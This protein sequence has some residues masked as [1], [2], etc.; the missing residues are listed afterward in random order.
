LVNILFSIILGLVQGV[1]EWLPISS[2]TQVLFASY[3]LFGL[4]IAA[5][6]AFG[7][8]LEIGSLGSA[9]TYFRKDIVALLHDR[10]LLTYLVVVTLFTAIVGAPL[11]YITDTY[12]QHASPFIGVPMIILG[13]ALVGIGF[14]IRYSRALPKIGGLEQMRI[15]HYI[16]VGIAQGIAA[17]PG[18]SRSGMTVSTMLIM[19]VKQD[20]AFRLSYL[21]YIPA[22]LGAFGVSLIFS[23][24]EINTDIQAVQPLGL[25]IAIITALLVGLVT[26][27]YLLKFAKTKNIW[28]L[29]IVLGIIAIVL[30]VTFTVFYYLLPGS[31]NV[32]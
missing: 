1:S 22:S 23:R 24:H 19:G 5:G 31:V 2:K 27:S 9:I 20:Q 11:Y 13:L 15:K 4:P 8:F 25:A 30:G 7:L 3:V 29:D 14:Y 26:I 16:I 18:V 21:A 32:S 12:L 6:Y 28:K 10:R 17:L